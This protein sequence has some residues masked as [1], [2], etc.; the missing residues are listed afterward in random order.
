MFE[1]I[2]ARKHLSIFLC[3][4]YKISTLDF[5]LFDMSDQSNNTYWNIDRIMRLI[6][7]LVIAAVII[8]LVR[9]LSDVLLPFFVACLIAYLLQPVV[10]FNQKILHTSRLALPSIVTVIEVAAVI[11]LLIYLFLPS[12][13]KDSDMLAGIVKSVTD[14]KQEVP[15]YCLRIIDFV[16]K[17]A[18]PEKLT[19]TLSKLRLDQLISKSSS[20]L[21]ESF[22][23]IVATLGWLLT[24]IYV[25]FILIDY[26]QIVRGFKLI[27]PR[28][29]RPQAISVV[30]DVQIN[31]NHYFRG[32]GLVA[33]CAMILYCIGFSIVGIPL[34]IPMGMLVGILYMIP[35]FQ[36]VTIIPVVVIC[37]LYSL[38]GD[39]NFWTL[40]WQCGLVY[41]VSQSICDYIIT[42]HVMGREM[43]LNPAIILLSL[44]IW[45]S[46]MGIIGMIIA[47]PLTS[48]IL[49]YYQRYISE[50]G[51]PQ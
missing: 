19:E 4:S 41:V 12:V 39:H 11:G 13:I 30:K 24:I 48:L 38:G 34:A 29:Y 14:G 44:S 9:Y 45:G 2:R 3:F 47:L 49:T 21:E 51:A 16:E 35:Y 42:P 1:E 10:A 28:K 40:I 18:N 5:T 23:V 20:L 26:P 37:F 17:Y 46:L 43:G 8:W 25:L 15:D 36:Y 22:H 27:F 32:Q 6:I 7:G 33:L 50:R 31:M